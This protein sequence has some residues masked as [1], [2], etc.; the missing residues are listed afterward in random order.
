MIV[1]CIYAKKF[2][3]DWI[4]RIYHDKTVAESVLLWLAKFDNTELKQMEMNEY[5]KGMF[6]R[7]L[8][9]FDDDVDVFISRDADSWLSIRDRN[10]IDEWLQ[11][12]KDFH[13]IRDHC[14]H[15]SP[16]MG[17]TFGARNNIFK[18]LN[19]KQL[20]EKYLQEN[21][22]H[23][24][25]I[26]LNRDVY[27]NIL[28][29]TFIHG[30]MN[31]RMQ[32]EQNAK[33]TP[34][35]YWDDIQELSLKI[36]GNLNPSYCDG[37]CKKGVHCGFVGCQIVKITDV[38]RSY[39]KK[40]KKEMNI[41][42]NIPGLGK[43]IISYS[44]Y[45]NIPKYTTNAIINCILSPH[46]YPDWICR[47]YVD[48]TVPKEMIQ[49]LKTFKHVEIIEMPIHKGSEAMLWRFLPASDKDVDMMI[50]RD[51]DSWL[52]TREAWCVAEW[53]ESNKDFHIIRDHCYHSQKIM[54]GMWGCTNGTIPNMKELV[55]EYSKNNTYDQG[56]LAEKIYPLIQNKLY[57]HYGHPQFNNQHKQ[58]YGY[59][60]DHG[61]PIPNY[62]EIDEYVSGLSFNE[63]HKLN[64]FFCA[65]CNKK[66]KTFIGA[67]LERIPS[68]ALEVVKNYVKSQNISFN[69]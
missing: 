33:P 56:F 66:H 37:M 54:G 38:C 47:F 41:E 36:M 46:V 53:I 62:Y 35:F 16:I 12:D 21:P 3:P 44:L 28:P 8:P 7:L 69:F 25:Q 45:N 15:R 34:D 55:E 48:E 17:G 32:Y 61:F 58:V 19:V 30:I 39:L 63:A 60:D 29:F 40:L 2:F 31:P 1:N 10:M 13:I 64:D 22:T 5:S 57:V 43:K 26:F 50:S 23:V 42:G 49:L 59:Y 65:H 51:A 9:G 4:V 11:S 52:S 27:K 68:R 20:M 18:K 24:D 14:H 67:I 6:W